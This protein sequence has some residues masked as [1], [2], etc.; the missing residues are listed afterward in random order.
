MITERKVCEQKKNRNCHGDDCMH[1][2]P[3]EMDAWV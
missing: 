3:R 2:K 1:I